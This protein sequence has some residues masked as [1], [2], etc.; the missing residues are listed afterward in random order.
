[1]KGFPVNSE[2]NPNTDKWKISQHCFSDKIRSEMTLPDKVQLNDITLREGRQLPGVSLKLEQVIEIADALVDAGVSMLQMHHDD[3][4]EMSEV[5][6][7]H[8]NVLIEAQYL[9]KYIISCFIIY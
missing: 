3:P 1:M 6:K 8:P 2:L 7:R 9:K 4:A 5:K